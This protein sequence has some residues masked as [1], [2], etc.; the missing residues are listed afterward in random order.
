MEFGGIG[1]VNELN[2][3]YLFGGEAAQLMLALCC[4][5]KTASTAKTGQIP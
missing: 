5:K 2:L 1:G 3:T 4:T